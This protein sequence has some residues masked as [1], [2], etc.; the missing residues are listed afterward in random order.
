[1]RRQ[2][3]E[4]RDGDVTRVQDGCE[5]EHQSREIK[6]GRNEESCFYFR[7][8]DGSGGFKLMLL[9]LNSRRRGSAV[10][11]AECKQSKEDK[12]NS[13]FS[14]SENCEFKFL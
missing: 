14:R 1:M 11:D 6:G 7:F 13:R 3:K 8:Q 12:L 10:I 5:I 9:N 4:R 2:E